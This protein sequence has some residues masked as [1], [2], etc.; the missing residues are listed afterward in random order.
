MNTAF[1][2]DALIHHVCIQT[3]DY[4]A[5][6]DFYTRLLGFEI[7]KESAG[8]HG[9]A[10]NAWLRQ[11]GF[12]LELQTA[13][14]GEQLVEWNPRASGPVHIGFLVSD[15]QASYRWFKQQGHAAFKCKNG[16][17]LYAVEGEYLFKAIAPEGTEIEIRDTEIMD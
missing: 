14:A 8:F 13:K 10:W 9:R 15:V 5:S 12:M 11:S 6:L 4:A 3:P 16:Q 7:V 17:E 1:S 2:Q